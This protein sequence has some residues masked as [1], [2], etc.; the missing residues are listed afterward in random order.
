MNIITKYIILPLLLAFSSCAEEKHIR[1]YKIKK[2]KLNKSIEEID[3]SETKPNF[4]WDVPKKWKEVEGHSMRI[5]S[6][7]LPGNGDLSITSFSGSSG[8]VKANVNR[9]EK[10]IGIVPSS[11]ED[12]NQISENRISRLGRYQVYELKKE[13]NKDLAIIAAIFPLKDVT[14]FVKLSINPNSLDALRA[15][16]VEF[17]DSIRNVTND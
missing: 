2:A 8:G 1:V 4:A 15:E 17:C 3:N 10:Q 12:I 16:F 6:F 9:W 7:Q 13:E 5:A 11:I 14:L